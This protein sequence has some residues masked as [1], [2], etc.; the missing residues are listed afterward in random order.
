MVLLV[1]NAIFRSV[2]E[3]IGNVKCL[4]TYVGECGPLV[5]GSLCQLSCRLCWGVV[6]V[7]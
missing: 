1:R 5:S 4:F 6:S 7:V 3:C 2:S